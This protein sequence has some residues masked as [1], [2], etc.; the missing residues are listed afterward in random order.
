MAAR[1]TVKLVEK[2]VGEADV[3]ILQANQIT[4]HDGLVFVKQVA[5]DPLLTEFT[6]PAEEIIGIFRCEDVRCIYRTIS[7]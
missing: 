1:V 7:K 4:I 3:A 2:M 6:I 5:E